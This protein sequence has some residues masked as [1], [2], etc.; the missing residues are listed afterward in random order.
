MFLA[1]VFSAGRTGSLLVAENL[2]NYFEVPVIKSPN[3]AKDIDL[4]KGVV[5]HTHEATLDLPSD[6]AIAVVCSRRDVFASVLSLSFSAETKQFHYFP[7]SAI[8][9][10]EPFYIDVEVFKSLHHYY[11]Q[12]YK[13]INQRSFNKRI[14]VCYE[15]VHADLKHLFSKFNIDQ[16]LS[17]TMLK[18]P[19]DYTQVVLNYK[20]LKDLHNDLILQ[21]NNT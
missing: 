19:Y 12:F 9:P 4:S 6:D 13:I 8:N 16:E 3:S 2:S 17:Y 21:Y 7:T 10:I 14:D 11:N 15:D 1:V 18:T 5:I 20:E